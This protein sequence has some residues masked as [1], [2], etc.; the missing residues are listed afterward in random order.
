VASKLPPSKTKHVTKRSDILWFL[1]TISYMGVCRLPAKTDYFPGYRSDVLPQHPCIKQSWTMFDYLWKCFH[2]FYSS[3]WDAPDQEILL[4]SNERR[5]G[6]NVRWNILTG[7]WPWQWNRQWWWR[8]GPRSSTTT[9]LVLWCCE[10]MDQTCK[11]SK[12]SKSL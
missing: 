12:K 3:W 7:R 2:I 9:Y 6:K 11:Q 4:E 1:A 8:R 10:R 5:R